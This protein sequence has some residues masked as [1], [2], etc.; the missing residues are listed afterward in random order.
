MNPVEARNYF[1][2]FLSLQLIRKKLFLKNPT[3]TKREVS[4]KFGG[5]RIFLCPVLVPKQSLTPFLTYLLSLPKVELQT[6]CK[7]SLHLQQSCS[8]QA[9]LSTLSPTQSGPPQEGGGAVQVRLLVVLP[10]PHDRLQEDQTDQP[11]QPPG[12]KGEEE[13]NGMKV[14][15]FP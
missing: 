7:P 9:F 2:Q 14:F 8:L 11:D 10:L 12:S 3:T 6:Y 5:F 1:L 13:T 15:L 4:F